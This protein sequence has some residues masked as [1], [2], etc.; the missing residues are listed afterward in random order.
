MSRSGL[1]GLSVERVLGPRRHAYAEKVIDDPR[2]FDAIE[3]HD[4]S[5]FSDPEGANYEEPGCG[6]VTPSGF[7]VYAHL[8][9]GGIDCCGDFG[10][11][12][13]ALAYGSELASIH[14][15]PMFDCVSSNRQSGSEVQR[16]DALLSMALML[17]DGC[18]QALDPLDGSFEDDRPAISA[19]RSVYEAG[20]AEIRR[21][22]QVNKDQSWSKTGTVNG[23]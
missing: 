12:S 5:S 3:V 18:L 20:I 7:S 23:K 14:H 6:R 11:R 21:Q 1:S 15:W 8:T 22:L 2:R 19:I 10:E 4:V 9:D 16:R 13:D 17:R